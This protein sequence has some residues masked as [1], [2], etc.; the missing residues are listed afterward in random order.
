MS[1]RT[2]AKIKLVQKRCAE[3]EILHER[4]KKPK[5]DDQHENSLNRVSRS[6]GARAAKCTQGRRCQKN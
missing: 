2:S 6:L 3:T 5:I 4:G 1:Y